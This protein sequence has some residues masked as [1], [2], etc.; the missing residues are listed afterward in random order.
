MSYFEIQ[1]E[2]K[3]HLL[4]FNLWNNKAIL[5]GTHISMQEL[6]PQNIKMNTGSKSKLS[7]H[8][9]FKTWQQQK[10]LPDLFLFFLPLTQQHFYHWKKRWGCEAN[11][12]NCAYMSMSGEK[13]SGIHNK[14][15]KLQGHPWPGL[16]NYMFT[17]TNFPLQWHFLFILAA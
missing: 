12:R 16:F 10:M 4:V 14:S 2:I 11:W 8:S 7:K 15:F 6:I 13:G 17:M 1:F 5:I 9:K 3:L